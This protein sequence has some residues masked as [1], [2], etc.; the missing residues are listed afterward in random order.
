MWDKM[1]KALAGIGGAIAGLFG[2]WD[3]ML[4]VLIGVMAVDYATGLLVAAMGKSPKT[5]TGHLDSK[6]GFRGLL[7][8]GV[9]LL[10]VLLGALLDL[11]LGTDAAMF[12]NM[13]IWFYIANEGISILENVALTDVPFPAWLKGALEQLRDREPRKRE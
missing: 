13:V 6:A 1:M 9:I 3:M 10:M 5:E 8:K 2:G 4:G 12:R 11:A 7:R